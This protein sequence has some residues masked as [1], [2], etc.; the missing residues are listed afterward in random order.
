[1]KVQA[2]GIALLTL[3]ALLL[4][5]CGGGGEAAPAAS[6]NLVGDAARGEALYQQNSI[7]SA[8]GCIACHSLEPDVVLVGPSH[9][10]IGTH[11]ATAVAGRS[12]EKYLHDSIVSPDAHVTE[13]Y[14]AGIMFQNYTGE[15]SEQQ[16]ADLVAFLLSKK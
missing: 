1:M 9:D 15:L 8:P 7:G 3:A 5:A 4:V 10:G 11:A 12:A 2:F 16:I 13:G 14:T 6:S